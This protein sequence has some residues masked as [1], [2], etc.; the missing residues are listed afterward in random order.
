MSDFGI[1]RVRL[2]IRHC[3]ANKGNGIV[4]DYGA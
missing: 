4:L 2:V 3:A 1:L